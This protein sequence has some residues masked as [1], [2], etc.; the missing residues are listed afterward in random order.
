MDY[1]A[2]FFTKTQFSFSGAPGRPQ[3]IKDYIRVQ[4]PA[5]EILVYDYYR[6]IGSENL[7]HGLIFDV[8][9]EDKR[10]SY[11]K[12]WSN[13]IRALICFTSKTEIPRLR[14]K[15]QISEE[16]KCKFEQRDLVAEPFNAKDSDVDFNIELF[17]EVN[18]ELNRKYKNDREAFD[19]VN[20]AIKYFSK[21]LDQEMQSDRFTM[22]YLSLEALGNKLLE[23]Y[24]SDSNIRVNH[25]DGTKEAFK[26]LFEDVD[27][28]DF[29]NDI[30]VDGRNK[31]F[32]EAK[33]DDA[34][35][36]VEQL[37]E[38]VQRCILEILGVNYNSYEDS[39]QKSPT[40]NK[41]DMAM[42]ITGQLENYDISKPNPEKKLPRIDTSNLE[43]AFSWDPEA[44]KFVAFILVGGEIINENKLE[45]ELKDRFI[46]V[47]NEEIKS[48]DFSKG[49]RK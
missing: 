29:E 16:D 42:H 35:E 3:E 18:R 33:E 5:G 23:K 36:W 4:L 7:H 12:T 2:R 39:L 24:D 13:M 44:G 45:G 10:K 34:I 48:I 47:E 11:A 27:G 38:G 37:E 49:Y 8:S 20:R 19:A 14:L 40:R 21:S 28:V 6:E 25:E 32:H 31:L 41:L 46:S 9:L 15:E 26:K 30:Y 17:K 43:R 1:F 22:L